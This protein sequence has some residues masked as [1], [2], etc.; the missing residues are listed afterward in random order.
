MSIGGKE[1][2]FGLEIT[3]EDLK[4][5]RQAVGSMSKDKDSSMSKDKA[6]KMKVARVEIALQYRLAPSWSSASTASR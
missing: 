6:S 5:R 1:D 3:V 2:V 4:K